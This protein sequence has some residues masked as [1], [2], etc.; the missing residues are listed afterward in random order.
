MFLSLYTVFM[1]GLVWFTPGYIAQVWN[2]PALSGILIFGIQL[3]EFL[4]GF[5]FGLY[6]SGVYEHVTWSE[7]TS[8]S[9]CRT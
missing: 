7:S 2:V 8:A 9:T 4:F 6:W 5:A 1:L 3:E